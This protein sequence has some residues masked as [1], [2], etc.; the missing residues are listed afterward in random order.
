[1]PGE[2]LFNVWLKIPRLKHFRPGSD[3]WP[4]TEEEGVA[5]TL[6]FLALTHYLHCE[7]D[8]RGNRAENE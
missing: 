6:L 3:P 7:N 2:R 4:K 5:L 1:M 8:D